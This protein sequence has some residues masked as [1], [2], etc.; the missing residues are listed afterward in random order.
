MSEVSAWQP[1]RR[2]HAESQLWSLPA[3][4]SA[5]RTV[6]AC[7]SGQLAR[8][9]LAA[10]APRLTAV[11]GELAG[12]ALRHGR[13]PFWANL[14]LLTGPDGEE[15]ARLVVV[16]CGPGFD[17]DAVRAGWSAGAAR[18]GEPEGLSGWLGWSPQADDPPRPGGGLLLVE[19]LSDAWGTIR[20]PPVHLVWADVAVVG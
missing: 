20:L 3:G 14:H 4:A 10:A 15:L 11:G 8:W 6:H 12:N 13:P 17:A 16:D 2:C 18:R 5:A 9:Q 7:L 1:Y 19:A